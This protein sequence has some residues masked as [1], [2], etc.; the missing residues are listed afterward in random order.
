M[1]EITKKLDSIHKKMNLIISKLDETQDLI[2]SSINRLN[3]QFEYD[4]DVKKLERKIVNG[5]AE[6]VYIQKES[7]KQEKELIKL[8]SLLNEKIIKDSE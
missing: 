1:K 8:F 7:L 2:I 4:A 3:T 6:C 5:I